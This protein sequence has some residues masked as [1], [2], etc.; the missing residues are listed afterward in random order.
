ML[1]SV[2]SSSATGANL[3]HL[4]ELSEKAMAFR[5]TSFGIFASRFETSRNLKV[6][7]ALATPLLR[8]FCQALPLIGCLG[9]PSIIFSRAQPT[10]HPRTFRPNFIFVWFRAAAAV[11]WSFP[12]QGPNQSDP[13]ASVSI[14][15]VQ[16]LQIS[17]APSRR[18]KFVVGGNKRWSRTLKRASFDSNAE[19][20]Q[21]RR[22]ASNSIKGM[23]AT[24]IL[25]I[26][27]FRYKIICGCWRAGTRYEFG[28]ASC[29]LCVTSRLLHVPNREGRPREESRSAN[30]WDGRYGEVPGPHSKLK[31]TIR[32][33]RMDIGLMVPRKLGWLNPSPSLTKSRCLKCKISKFQEDCN[34]PIFLLF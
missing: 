24:W 3:H 18:T 12:C 11:A 21:Q 23:R 19:R 22:I 27:S 4:I 26:S 2:L 7:P 9:Y 6:V 30:V 25:W 1:N 13:S 17:C 16:R 29:V 31:R 34:S 5:M 15:S 33:E 20:Y 10:A 14:R 8:E 32:A 28:P